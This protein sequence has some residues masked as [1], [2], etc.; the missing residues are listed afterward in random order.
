MLRNTSDAAACLSRAA[1]CCCLCRQSGRPRVY[2]AHGVKDSLFP[3]AQTGRSVASR[4]K[5]MLPP[6]NVAYAEHTGAHE[7]TPAVAKQALTWLFSS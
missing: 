5:R 3:V 4:L 7:V 2:V 6:G 1:P